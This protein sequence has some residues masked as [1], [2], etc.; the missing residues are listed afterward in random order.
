MSR[1]T[2]VP[3][4]PGTLSQAGTGNADFTAY[5]QP[6]GIDQYN[7]RDAAVDLPQLANLGTTGIITLNSASAPIGTGASNWQHTGLSP[8]APSSAITPATE[9]PLVDGAGNPTP[10]GPLGWNL[11]AGQVLRVYWDLSVRPE[12][13]GTPWVGAD[14]EIDIQVGMTPGVQ[15]VNMGAHC[16]LISLQWDVTSAA[17]VNFTE[18][19]GQTAYTSAIGGT[20]GG[21]LSDSP[22]S[23]PVPAWKL[24]T[25]NVADGTWQG[26]SQEVAREVKWTS[27]NGAW[28][29]LPSGAITVYGLRL[30]I[31]GIYHPGQTATENYLLLDTVV[32][33]VAQILKYDGGTL[34]AIQQRL[35][36]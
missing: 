4:I 36:V 27:A 32:G 18:V 15:V 3:L 10:L 25:I 11:D 29:Y 9:T 31:H 23:V 26:G 2:R 30:V 13:D 21:K 22:A 5:T 12:Y 24:S 6:G 28:Y 7:L 34:T 14:G 16:W 35:G 33:G 20:V 1:I 17:L 19:S 8:Q